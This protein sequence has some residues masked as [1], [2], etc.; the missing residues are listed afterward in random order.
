MV[1]LI[2]NPL[3]SA[4]SERNRPLNASGLAHEVVNPNGVCRPMP[5][6]SRSVKGWV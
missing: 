1:G 4:L 3:S 2:E 5:K 6:T